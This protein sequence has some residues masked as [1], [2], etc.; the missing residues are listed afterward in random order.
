MRQVEFFVEGTPKPQGSKKTFINHKTGKAVIVE[1]AGDP[2]KKWRKRVAE[3]A[4]V[5]YFSEPVHSTSEPVH[6]ASEPVHSASEPFT[7]CVRVS[8]IFRLKRPK[9]HYRTGKFSDVLKEEHVATRHGKR[10]DADKLARAVL[11]GLTGVVFVDDSQV[12]DLSVL[13]TWQKRDEPEG[14]YIK[15][16][17]IQG[18]G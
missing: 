11:D 16:T 12:F 15:V 1:A 5:H 2:L 6:S 3:E 10:P 17:E 14:C 8:L 4:S 9:S 13:K 18:N 7:K